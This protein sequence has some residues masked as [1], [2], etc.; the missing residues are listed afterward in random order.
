MKTENQTETAI[1]VQLPEVTELVQKSGIELTK[2]EAHV[3]AFKDKFESL[4]ELSRPLADL[5]KENPSDED[6][7]IAR[8][9]RL[10][11]VKIR[12]G[13]E[14]VKD[15]RKAVLLTESNLIQGIFNMVKNSCILTEGQYE[16][17]ENH[18]ERIEKERKEKIRE[19]RLS[20]LA[21]FE[22]DTTYLFEALC[23]MEDAKFDQLLKDSELLFQTK[24]ENERRAEEERLAAIETKRLAAIEREKEAQRIREEN[25]RLRLEAEA[26]EKELQIERDR[27]EK[28]RRDAEAKAE[29]ER[30]ALIAEQKKETDRI[31]AIQK[32]KDEKASA[33]RAALQA[34][35]LAKEKADQERKEAE[36]ARIAAEEKAKKDAMLA[37]DKEKLQSLAI[38]FSLVELPELATTEAQL[39]IEN[40]KILQGKLINYIKEQS[41]KL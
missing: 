21:P 28:E 34:E 23:D 7:A 25:E 29:A 24:K 3:F 27:V 6:A 33:E 31:A 17:I 4:A 26:K 10:A 39:I 41:E 16:A 30:Q 35:L 13:A 38:T 12:T 37:P 8:K 1:A 19:E 15:E 40:I 32:E 20:K 14:S 2:A 11:L 22:V 18:R 36:N 5:N 9:T